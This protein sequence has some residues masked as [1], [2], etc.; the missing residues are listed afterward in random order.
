MWHIAIAADGTL[1]TTDLSLWLQ[2]PYASYADMGEIPNYFIHNL[3]VEPIFSQE[4]AVKEIFKQK[5]KS[6][7]APIFKQR[8]RLNKKTYGPE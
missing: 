6:F 8:I 3:I 1:D 2:Y 7:I 4:V 5:R